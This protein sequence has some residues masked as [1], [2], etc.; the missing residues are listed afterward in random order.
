MI[1]G[2]QIFLGVFTIMLFIT[3]VVILMELDELYAIVNN[4]LTMMKTTSQKHKKAIDSKC[5]DIHTPHN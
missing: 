3:Q 4:L 1:V 5:E 2:V